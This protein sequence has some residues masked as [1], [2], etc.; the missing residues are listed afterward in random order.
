MSDKDDSDNYFFVLCEYFQLFIKQTVD[1]HE[2]YNTPSGRYIVYEKETPASVSIDPQ[3]ITY[4]VA[5]V[6]T[7]DQKSCYDIGKKE[8]EW[9]ENFA[10]W[11][12]HRGNRPELSIGN[13]DFLKDLAQLAVLGKNGLLQ[14][15]QAD[16]E[17]NTNVLELNLS[18][19][20]F[21]SAYNNTLF[22]FQSEL[23]AFKTWEIDKNKSMDPRAKS[24]LEKR[25][26]R[27]ETEIRLHAHNVKN[28]V[29][30]D[31]TWQELVS[32][33]TMV[34]KIIKHT[35]KDEHDVVLEQLSQLCM[36]KYG[37]MCALNVIINLYP[38][39]ENI[40]YDAL[41]CSAVFCM[42]PRQMSIDALQD[43]SASEESK[44]FNWRKNGIKRQ[45]EK[46]T[47]KIQPRS[48]WCYYLKY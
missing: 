26:V 12:F 24:T 42:F 17:S 14:L 41:L 28:G 39:V 2:Q 29:L 36:Y 37:E 30:F 9:Q 7:H 23:S 35:D 5:Y 33:R 34:D 1:A 43:E 31:E 46:A 10:D 47:E 16:V 13:H 8:V 6:D 48:A 32:M 21:T 22:Q 15:L 4:C 20:C 40:E 45:K 19:V 27:E 11:L 25:H 18:G 44:S 38:S 3:Y